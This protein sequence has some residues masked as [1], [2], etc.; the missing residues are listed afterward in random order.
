MQLTFFQNTTKG[1]VS[2]NL[3]DFFGK[4]GGYQQV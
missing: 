1:E 3:K 4:F 2:L